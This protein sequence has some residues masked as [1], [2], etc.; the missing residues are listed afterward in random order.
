M[1]LEMRRECEGCRAPLS[2]DSETA[3]ICSYECTFC[4]PA[5]TNRTASARIAAVSWYGGHDA[6]RDDEAA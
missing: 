2:A 1:A 6:S 4:R 3:Y 5:P